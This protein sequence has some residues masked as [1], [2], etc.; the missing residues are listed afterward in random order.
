MKHTDEKRAKDNA[1]YHANKARI[2]ENRLRRYS[3]DPSSRL[4]LNVKSQRKRRTGFTHEEYSALWEA[5]KGRCFLCDS[6]EGVRALHAD[7]CHTTGTKRRLLCGA[8]NKGLGMFRD[9]PHL[10][11]KAAEYLRAH[12]GSH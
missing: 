10:L 11:D 6:P 1:Y 9:N 3:E 7:H 5:Q 12:G 4:A 8:C 2:N